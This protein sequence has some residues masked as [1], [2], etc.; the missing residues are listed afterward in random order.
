MILWEMVTKVTPWRNVQ[1]DCKVKEQVIFVEHQLPPYLLTC[2]D[3]KH[4]STSIL[5]L[6]YI[7]SSTTSSTR[8][9]GE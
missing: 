4:H 1:Q 5:L 6:S 2:A 3:C 7:S 9:D 8:L